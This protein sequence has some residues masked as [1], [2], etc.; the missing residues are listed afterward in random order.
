VELSHFYCR[1]IDFNRRAV[2]TARE[3]G[4]P[5][6][7]TS[8]AHQRRQFHTTWSEV[9]AEPDPASVIE[10]VKAGKTTPC[11]TPLPLTTLIRINTLMV[12]RNHFVQRVSGLSGAGHEGSER[13]LPKR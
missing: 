2:K 12:W 13:T 10:A 11:T 7:G 9:D 8:D 3:H 6:V 1:S 5:L 4:L